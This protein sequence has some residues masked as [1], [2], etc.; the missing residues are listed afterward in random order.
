MRIYI[1]KEEALLD[2]DSP[3]PGVI[4]DRNIAAFS[5]EKAA[6]EELTRL[7]KES[8]EYFRYYIDPIPLKD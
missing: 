8:D 6:K 7:Q 5:N 4:R 3:V 2:P 1:V